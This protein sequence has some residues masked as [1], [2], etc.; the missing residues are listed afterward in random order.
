MFYA[1][2]LRGLLKV[3]PLVV[4]VLLAFSFSWPYAPATHLSATSLSNPQTSPQTSYSLS[5][6]TVPTTGAGPWWITSDQAGKMWFTENVTNKIGR[7]DPSS[8]AFTEW[9][10][11]GGGSPR[12]A[13][14]TQVMVGGINSTRVYFTLYSSNQIAY[15]DSWNGTFYEWSLPAGSNPVGIY[16]DVNGTVWFTESGRDT[17]G[18]LAPERNQLTEWTLPGATA[19][20]GSP[21]LKPWGIYAQSVLTGPFNNVTD[22]HVWFTESDSNSIGQLQATN[23][24][25]KIWDLN[26]LNIIPG[27]QYGPTDLTIDSTRPGNLLFTDSLA[28]RLSV[29]TNAASGVYKEYSL[30]A[31]A[32]LAKPTSLSID[33]Q[34]G[35]TWFTEFNTGIL[36]IWNTTTLA[37]PYLPPTPST[38]SITPAVTIPAPIIT[39]GVNGTSTIQNPQTSTISTGQTIQ[40]ITEYPLPNSTAQPNSVIVDPSGNVWFT[41]SNPAVNKIG[42]LSTPYVF[43]ISTSPTAQVTSQGGTVSYM[44]SVSLISGLPLPVQ[45]SLQNVPSNVSASLSALTGTPPFTSTLTVSTS[46]LTPP[47]TY[48]IDVIATSGTQTET[49]AVTLTVQGPAPPPTFDY[50]IDV[51]GPS[52]LTVQQGQATDFTLEISLISGTTQPVNLSVGSLPPEASY[53]LTTNSGQPPFNV[54]LNLQTSLNTPAGSYPITITG[55]SDGGQPH[56]PTQTATLV[57]TEVPRDFSITT[58]GSV[59]LV[60][61]SRVYV[62]V[63]I[64][65]IGY[66]QSNVSLNGSFSPSVPGLSVNFNPSSVAPQ[67]NGTSQIVMEIT[68][69]QN[70]AGQPYQLTIVGTSST[71]SRTHQV[72]LEVNVSPCLIATASF[73]SSSAPEVQLLR[74][75]R[76]NQVMPTF[77]GSMFMSVFNSWYYSFS[78]NVAL[79]ENS[80]PTARNAIRMSLYPLIMILRLGSMT[81][82][83]LGT[84]PELAAFTTGILTS[85]LVGFTYLSLPSYLILNAF[86]RRVTIRAAK[87]V[88]LWLTGSFVISIAIFIVSEVFTINTSMMVATTGL[89][90]SALAFG[91][92]F[93]ALTTFE[94]LRRDTRS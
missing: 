46:P 51:T 10:I 11:P 40:A 84:I 27:L 50:R 5:E 18:K 63:T 87:T 13:V 89:A 15:F 85:F 77:A 24:A 72:T 6:W 37:I 58:V 42:R 3:G 35:V 19:T 57:V 17:I 16:V 45:L 36:G 61:G 78:P 47:S 21:L 30:P 56:H 73:G 62:P 74:N 69:L 43:Q 31:H 32:S 75:F 41:E 25:L 92:I 4:L 34:R 53:F 65:S 23:G 67:L 60:Q 44:V 70:S 8:N 33:N 1:S 7:Y 9:S 52:T 81:F 88:K 55:V 68:A 54:T 28:D 2:H 82:S 93:P 20:A 79:Y 22:R 26:S 64:T 12:Y 86:K 39:T 83:E 48:T 59:N 71:P 76:D 66:F 90:L 38:F 94:R 14:T 91:A 80:H 49:S 29:L